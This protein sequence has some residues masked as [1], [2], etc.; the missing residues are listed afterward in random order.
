MRTPPQNAGSMSA[1]DPAREMLPPVE[2]QIHWAPSV[3]EADWIAPRVGNLGEGVT[4]IVPK[5][6]EAYVRILH[7]AWLE[8]NG[9]NGATPVRWRAIAE[10][11]GVDLGRLA[12]FHSVA[13]NPRW[14]DGEP[15]YDRG[16]EAGSMS[17]HDLEA[18]ISILK[19]WTQKPNDCFFCVWEGWG[20]LKAPPEVDR[21]PRVRLPWRDHLLYEGPI[22]TALLN[23]AHRKIAQHQTSKDP[24]LYDTM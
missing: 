13:L 21:G 20:C 24:G 2:T 8:A 7:P 16:P 3:S 10:W 18:L 15:P 12:Q 11:S 19:R 4:S 17:Q 6:F 1:G 23:V 5:D 9:A 22:E 14:V